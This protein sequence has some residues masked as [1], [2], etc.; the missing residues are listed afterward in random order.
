MQK[1]DGTDKIVLLLGPGDL[2][3]LGWQTNL[4]RQH[5]IVSV[6]KERQ[7]RTDPVTIGS[8]VSLVFRDIKTT[9][10]LA[11]ARAKAEA[12]EKRRAKAQTAKPVKKRAKKSVE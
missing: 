8:R 5:A 4:V 10:P 9:I 6:V 11:R 3:V 2:F 1:P 12:T 7:K